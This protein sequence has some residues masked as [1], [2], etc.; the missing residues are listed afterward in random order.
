[1]FVWNA[2]SSANFCSCIFSSLLFSPT[3]LISD[4]QKTRTLSGPDSQPSGC[5]TAAVFGNHVNHAIAD[6]SASVSVITLLQIH[7][8]NSHG[9]SRLVCSV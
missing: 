7:M 6:N 1:M 3:K 5:S 8:G 4:L 2:A 9:F